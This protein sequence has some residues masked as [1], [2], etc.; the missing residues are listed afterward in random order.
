MTNQPRAF[1]QS[2]LGMIQ[3]LKMINIIAG[4]I[5][6]AKSVGY[7]R[8]IPES[9]TFESVLSNVGEKT[10]L[11]DDTHGPIQ[12]TDQMFDLAIEG[13]A[14]F[15]V[16]GKDGVVPTRNGKFRLNEKGNLSDQDGQEV[17][18][19]EKTDKP[20]SLAK[21]YDI[22]I[23]QNGEITVGT[24]R[25]GRLA[26]RIMDNKPVKVHQGYLEGSNVNLMNEM[27][28]LAMTYRAFESTEK[29][30]SMELS[31]DKELIEKYGRN[32]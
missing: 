9:A 23:N 24:E 11:R 27:V 18:V 1:G 13:N 16:E 2:L 28:G 21:D 31:A 22:S 20:I 8:Q 6:N 26:M 7:Q 15:L 32:V 5:A 30:L 19:V 3:R 25:Y 29:M 4:N 10:P 12:K 17:V 14:Y